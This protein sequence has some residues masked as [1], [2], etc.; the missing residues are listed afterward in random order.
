MKRK[1]NHNLYLNCN[2]LR[3]DVF[4]GEKF[5]YGWHRDNNTNIPGSNFIQLWMPLNDFLGKG[6]GGLKI[7][8]KSHK[9]NTMTSETKNEMKRLIGNVPMR[10]SIKAKVYGH[11]LFN[12]KLIE[13][14]PG[15]ALIFHQGLMHKGDINI[16]KKKVRYVCGCFYHDVRSLEKKF[17]NRDFK[18]KNIKGIYSS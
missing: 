16:L 15:Q 17:I 3:M 8:E 2:A 9:K 18:D 11:E 12:E 13:L 4:N 14:Y 6:L 5:M 1:S 10:T 7:L